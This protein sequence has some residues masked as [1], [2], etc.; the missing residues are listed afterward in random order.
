MLAYSDF[1]DIAPDGRSIVLV[2]GEGRDTSTNKHLILVDLASI[3]PRVPPT[4]RPIR[5][6]STVSAV[7]KAVSL[8]TLCPIG[9]SSPE[10]ICTQ[11]A[12]TWLWCGTLRPRTPHHRARTAD[13]RVSQ[14]GVRLGR[15]PHMHLVV[16]D[17]RQQG[18]HSG[19]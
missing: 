19:R 18:A 1:L 12:L 10:Q 11:V 15:K 2:A 9:S 17:T 7:S 4:P 14:S 16:Y 8:I 13:K 3:I 6:K 5:T